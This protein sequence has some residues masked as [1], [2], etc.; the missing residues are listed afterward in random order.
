MQNTKR[1]TFISNK[2][3][4]NLDELWQNCFAGPDNFNHMNAHV[5]FLFTEQWQLNRIFDN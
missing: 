3:E 4:N 5:P 1:L 2:T